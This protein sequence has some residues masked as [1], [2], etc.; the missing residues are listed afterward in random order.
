MGISYAVTVS[1]AANTKGMMATTNKGR[2]CL[3]LLMVLSSLSSYDRF[4]AA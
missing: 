2:V 4:Y 3:K 1:A